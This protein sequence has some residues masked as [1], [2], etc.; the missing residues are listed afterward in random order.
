M[1]IGI[2]AFGALGDHSGIYRYLTMLLRELSIIAPDERFEVL[3]HPRDKLEFSGRL[4][5]VRL[6]HIGKETSRAIDDIAWHFLQL[7]QLCKTRGYEVLF[8]PAANRRAT[9]RC[10][11]PTVGTVHDLASFHVP[12]KYSPTRMFYNRNVIPIFMRCLTKI[13]ANSECTKSDL[14]LYAHV[15]ATRISVIP[16]A[17]DTATFYPRE[18]SIAV[19]H[20]NRKLGIRFPYVL[21]VSRIESP[22]KNHLRLMD[23]FLKVKDRRSLPHQLVI[24]GE[25]SHGADVVHRAFRKYQIGHDIKLLGFVPNVTLPDLYCAADA[26][27][28]PS[29]YEGFGLPVLEAMACGVPVACSRAGSLPEVAGEAAIFFDPTQEQEIE[30]AIERLV[31]DRALRQECVQK[32]LMQAQRFSWRLTAQRTLEVLRAAAGEK[33]Q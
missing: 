13:I 5:R 29:L 26:F 4:N 21:Y 32:G 30:T 19:E 9:A 20:V 31:E 14:V 12:G 33:K 3:L 15:P 25:E 8:L 23:A 1:N 16:E 28:F 7:P 17:T 6:V 24:A 22:G 18:Q 11:C 27:V 2:A 10:S